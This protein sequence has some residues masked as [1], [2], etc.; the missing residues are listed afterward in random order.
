[1]LS[2]YDAS[3]IRLGAHK[4]KNPQKGLTSECAVSPFCGFV[5]VWKCGGLLRAVCLL[6]NLGFE[7]A[8]ADSIRAA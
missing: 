7:F 3:Q 8:G 2:P 5:Y 4:E 1:M 6:G